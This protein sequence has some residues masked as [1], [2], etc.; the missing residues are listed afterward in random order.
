MNNSIKNYLG[1]AGIIAILLAGWS[2]W[3]YVNAYSESIQPSSY[4]SFSVSAEG[5]VVA[6]PDVAQFSFSVI[7]Q[8]GK[9]LAALQKDNT[10]KVNKAIAFVKSKGVDSK[11]I[12]TQG[13]NVTPRYQYYACTTGA[14]VCRPAE[15]VGYEVNQTV[16]VKI[17]NFDTTG[18][19]L[20]GVVTNGANTVTQLNFTVD[21]PTALQD[22]ARNQAIKKAKDKASQVAAAGGFKVGRL[23]SIEEGNYVPYT[24]AYDYAMPSAAGVSAKESA[25]APTIEPG[26][27]EITTNVTLRYEIK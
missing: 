12:E 11:D 13:Y 14:E 18:D 2:Y 27:Q 7:S 1:I 24:R 4:R 21:D 20:S 22:N 3:H 16:S 17:R 6:I 10:L 8:G 19:I 5:K 25:P 15:I 26:S 9:D 23:L